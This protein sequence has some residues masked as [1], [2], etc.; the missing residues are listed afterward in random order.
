M[1]INPHNN[2]NAVAALA[3]HV[4][5]VLNANLWT[6][7]GEPL[8]ICAEEIAAVA[9][10][11]V[12]TAAI[13]IEAIACTGGLVL[14]DNEPGARWFAAAVDED[15]PAARRAGRSFEA[16]AEIA[17]GIATEAEAEAAALRHGITNAAQLLDEATALDGRP[18]A[19][20]AGARDLLGK[21][22]K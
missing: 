14:V 13:A 17:A 10:V 11:G 16:A 15:D 9:G 5:A 18:A 1:A 3:K 6:E 12:G 7:A 20:I 2:N 4:V 21:L 19:A 8:V 22:L